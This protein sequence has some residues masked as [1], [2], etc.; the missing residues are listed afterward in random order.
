MVILI[1]AF[2]YYCHSVLAAALQCY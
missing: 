1:T 2:Y